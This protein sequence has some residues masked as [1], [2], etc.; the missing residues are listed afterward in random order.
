MR[1]AYPAVFFCALAC[2]SAPSSAPNRLVSSSKNAP[3]M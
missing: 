2:A 1:F 3:S